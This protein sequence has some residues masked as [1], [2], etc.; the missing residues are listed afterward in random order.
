MEGAGMARVEVE[1]IVEQKYFKSL[2][3][4]VSRMEHICKLLALFVSMD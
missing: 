3:P 4:G 1:C 2:L